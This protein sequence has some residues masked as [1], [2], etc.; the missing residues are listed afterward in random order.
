MSKLSDGRLIVRYIRECQNCDM[1]L[2][3]ITNTKRPKYKFFY[4]LNHRI[5]KINQN[6][7]TEIN[8]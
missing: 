4:S 1:S 7:Q 5:K 2:T 8:K 3:I 6:A